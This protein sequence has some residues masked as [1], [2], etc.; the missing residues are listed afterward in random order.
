M[1][2]NT[3]RK[4]VT[5]SEIVE[6]IANGIRREHLRYLVQLGVVRPKERAGGKG[7]PWEFSRDDAELIRLI[8]NERKHGFTWEA[9]IDR[10]RDRR[11]NPELLRH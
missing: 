4:I 10:A 9:S 7:R 2:K 3:I 5:T 8:W 1:P 11:R 6:S